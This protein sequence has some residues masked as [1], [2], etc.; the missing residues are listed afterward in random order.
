MA[1][2]DKSG[3]VE[4]V[5]Q[6]ATV[7]TETTETEET[8]NEPLLA[9]GLTGE[10]VQRIKG[11]L[12][13]LVRSNEG[14]V[15][16]LNRSRRVGVDNRKSKKTEEDKRP[17]IRYNLLF[18]LPEALIPV[19]N[20]LEGE[21][22]AGW[23]HLILHATKH[24]NVAGNKEGAFFNGKTEPALTAAE[25]AALDKSTLFNDLCALGVAELDKINAKL[26]EVSES[27]GVEREYRQTS[28]ELRGKFETALRNLGTFGTA[29]AKVAELVESATA[30]GNGDK[31][32][33]LAENYN[34]CTASYVRN[35]YAGKVDAKPERVAKMRELVN[36]FRAKM[37]DES[38]L[39]DF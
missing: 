35:V 5:E 21:Q 13:V 1:K 6:V 9:T 14:Y 17:Q 36:G 24:W 25:F 11:G 22:L 15:G 23:F 39:A 10:L 12:T 16:C 30:N 26:A 29:A 3:N 18:K 4:T 28:D 38:G 32:K 31:A 19:V 8:S 37:A 2:N 7:E 27:E 34:L 20:S 33:V